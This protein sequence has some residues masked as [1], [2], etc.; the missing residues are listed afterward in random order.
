MKWFPRESH[1]FY[2]TEDKL[3]IIERD[4]RDKRNNLVLSD[5]KSGLNILGIESEGKAAIFT[6]GSAE[7]GR[8]FW[9]R[10]L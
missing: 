6:S 4:D 8:I 9:S 7:S 10:E 3:N 1:V 5:E 2:V